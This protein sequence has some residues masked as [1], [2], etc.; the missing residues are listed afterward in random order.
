MNALALVRPLTPPAST[1]GEPPGLGRGARRATGTA[2][3]G[4]RL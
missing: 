3:H 2:G 1:A 4:R